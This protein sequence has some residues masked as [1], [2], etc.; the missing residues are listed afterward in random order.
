MEKSPIAACL[1][2]TDG[3]RGSLD[4]VDDNKSEKKASTICT[5]IIRGGLGKKTPSTGPQI[6]K[7][8]DGEEYTF[9][10]FNFLYAFFSLL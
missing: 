8:V 1:F 6:Q 7:D 2:V 10:S 4:K 9:R 3:A 5:I